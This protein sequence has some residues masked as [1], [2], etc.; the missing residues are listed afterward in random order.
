MI[1]DLGDVND[2]SEGRDWSDG[3]REWMKADCYGLPGGPVIWVIEQGDRTV[4]IRCEDYNWRRCVKE[5][6]EGLILEFGVRAGA[7]L[8]HIAKAAKQQVYGFDWWKGLPHSH[9]GFT[10][11][12]CKANR[13]TDMPE[14][15]ILVDGLFSDTLEDFLENHSGAVGFVNIDCDLYSSSYYVLRCLVDRF[16]KGSLLALS[17]MAFSP[18][19]QRRAWQRYLMET[20][21]DWEMVGKNHPWGE[22]YRR[23]R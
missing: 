22:V 21:Q 16:V 2:L 15:V 19:A 11:G 20:L 23:M 12:D 3:P 14:N 7:S 9:G 8:K 13:P 4:E 17:D 6:P 10:R 1:Y 18:V 5:A